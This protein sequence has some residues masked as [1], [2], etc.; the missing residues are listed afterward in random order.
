MSLWD[1]KRAGLL[2]DA[3]SIYVTTAGDDA[4]CEQLV[5]VLHR[6]KDASTKDHTNAY[7][8]GEIHSELCAYCTIKNLF[9][10]KGYRNQPECA[11]MESAFGE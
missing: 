11:F 6:A 1:R 5:H 10:C 4:S 9:N 7:E 2:C 8:T 3:V